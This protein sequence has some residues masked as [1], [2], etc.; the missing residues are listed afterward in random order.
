MM[1][2]DRNLESVKTFFDAVLN[3]GDL[4]GLSSL[5]RGDILV[6]EFGP[7]LE[8]LRSSLLQLRATFSSPEYRIMD[9]VS[10]GDKVVVRF[11]AKATHSGRY[12]G[13]PATGKRLK[14]WGVM[15]FRFD[16]GAITEFWSLIDSQS[17]LKQLREP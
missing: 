4:E 8:S 9:T 15:V 2:P 3:G 6:P 16:A 12:L 10:Q 13:L 11:S 14:L 7:G 5:V 17:V 1:P